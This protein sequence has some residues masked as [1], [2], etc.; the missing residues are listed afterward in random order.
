MATPRVFFKV[1]I[2]KYKKGWIWGY[3]DSFCL[4]LIK[5][6]YWT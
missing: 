4:K 5:L 3:D 2:I 1:T 6:D